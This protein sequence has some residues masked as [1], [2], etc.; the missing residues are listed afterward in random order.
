M[1]SQT[2]KLTTLVTTLI[3]IVFIGT[4]LGLIVLTDE[5]D[6]FAHHGSQ[7]SIIRELGAL[8]FVTAS[9]SVFW[10][11]F[12]KRS[13][14]HEVVELV[15]I[16]E[17]VEESGVSRLCKDFYHAPPWA[18]LFKDT[19]E[20]DMVVS[21]ART[22]RSMHH[23]HL[24]ALS[25]DPKCRIR[26]VL[27]DPNCQ[28]LV[29]ELARRYEKTV[30]EMLASMNEAVREYTDFLGRGSA[31]FELHLS[32][33]SCLYT[34]YRFNDSIVVSFLPNHKVM[35]TERPTIV[36]ERSGIFPTIFR[37]DFDALVAQSTLNYS[38]PAATPNAPANA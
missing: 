26:V 6:Y 1:P 20:F 4:G 9:I 36:L 35:R 2:K 5:L 24:T 37:R 14:L 27:A 7:K 33:R 30:E 19:T 15:R 22:W 13:F 23:S 18:E 12:A 8:M 29:A 34:Y 10:E 25:N 17:N 21:Y 32:K 31:S 38:N 11:L 3:A 28:E 16:S